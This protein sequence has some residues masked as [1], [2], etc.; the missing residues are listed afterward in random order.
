MTDKSSFE[1]EWK[2]ISKSLIFRDEVKKSATKRQF[3]KL[4]TS[5]KKSDFLILPNNLIL[6]LSEIV[7]GTFLRFPFFCQKHGFSNFRSDF[8]LFR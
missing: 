2:L 7:E 4:S 5:D 1:D 6:G 8:P 3:E